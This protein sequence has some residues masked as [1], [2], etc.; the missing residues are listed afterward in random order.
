MDRAHRLQ[1]WFGM[2]SFVTLQPASY[3]GRVMDEQASFFGPA[4]C[5]GRHPEVLSGFYVINVSRFIMRT[6]VSWV[7]RLQG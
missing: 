5:L 6:A 3:S 4:A 7:I 1:D 2:G